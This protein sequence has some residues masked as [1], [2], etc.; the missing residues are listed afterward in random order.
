MILEPDACTKD[1]KQYVDCTGDCKNVKNIDEGIF[2]DIFTYDEVINL[3]A[4]TGFLTLVGVLTLGLFCCWFRK[5]EIRKR[6]KKCKA[7]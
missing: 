4:F 5:A 7:I 1:Y 6:K 2:G 3:M